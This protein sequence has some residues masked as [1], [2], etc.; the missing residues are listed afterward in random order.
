[1]L[2]VRTIWGPHRAPIFLRMSGEKMRAF[3][4]IELMI[5]TAIIGILAAVSIPNFLKF[6]CRARTAEAKGNLGGIFIAETAYLGGERGNTYGTF[7]Q[8]GW[9]PLGSICVYSYTIAGGGV[10]PVSCGVGSM[11]D[12]TTEIRNTK[13]PPI[14]DSAA[15]G[16][17]IA[18][19]GGPTASVMTGGTYFRANAQGAPSGNSPSIDSWTIDSSKNVVQTCSGC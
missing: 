9:Q 14:A 15:C 1:M 10:N 7:G 17:G 8:V 19:N 18:L 6:Q 5:V 2:A 16:S 12:G 13:G 11:A 3:T 4:L